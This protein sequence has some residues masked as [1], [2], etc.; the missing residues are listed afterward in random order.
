MRSIRRQQAVPIKRA[1]DSLLD[2]IETNA[3]DETW[4]TSQVS[5]TGD[6]VM[7]TGL[8]ALD[9]VLRGGVRRGEVVA[10]EADSDAQARALLAS[11]AR[12][13]SARVQIDGDDVLRLTAELVAGASEVPAVILRSGAMH[14]H[15]WNAVCDAIGDLSTREL[16][17]S[18]VGS[19][20]ALAAALGES[21]VELVV[22]HDLARFGEPGGVLALLEDLAGETCVAVIASHRPLG[23]L[24][25]P[26]PAGVR[27]I[28]LHSYALGGRAK[29]FSAGSS[30]RQ[31]VSHLE[32]DCLRY[33]V[34]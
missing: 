5:P 14:D 2:E 23:P 22:I 25:A 16:N 27:Q 4:W 26:I 30:E 18:S 17:I 34:A 32:V 9:R 3:I 11:A 12:L 10:V 19:V 20:G 6:H 29:L 31:A 15:E 1:L 28:C 8:E 33:R 21:S 13:T 24:S 7:S